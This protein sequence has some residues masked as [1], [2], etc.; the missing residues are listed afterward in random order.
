MILISRFERDAYSYKGKREVRYKAIFAYEKSDGTSERITKRFRTQAEAKNHLQSLEREH[1]TKGSRI[2]HRQ[3]L[4]RDYA[5]AYR[6]AN[7]KKLRS[8]KGEAGK[9]DLMIEFF[10]D[11]KLEKLRRSEIK[12]FKA[13]LE[14]TKHPKTR[15]VRNG[16]T[17]KFEIEDVSKPRQPRTIN[18]YLE[19]LRAILNEAETDEKILAAPSFKGLI[20]SHLEVSRDMT[21]TYAEFER[22]LAACDVER[23]NHTREHLKLPLIALWELGCRKEELQKILV[24]DIDPEARIVMVWEGKRKNPKQRACY[25]SD[26]LLDAIVENRVMSQPADARAFGEHRYYARSFQTAKKIAG[27]DE[28]FRLND[29]RHCNITNKIQAGMD[30]VVVQKSV[31]HSAKSAMTLDVYTNLQPEYIRTS[32]QKVEVYSRK[33][34]EEAKC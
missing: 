31:G 10:G 2:E 24:G 32:H 7:L 14:S 28:R 30:L 11:I 16:K 21:I 22:L 26:R 3:L 33:Q 23:S 17:K 27:I 8:Y 1:A 12:S 6:E 5:E 29:I 25:I 4:F 18:T 9:V 34:L 20:D 13:Y 19:R 15:K